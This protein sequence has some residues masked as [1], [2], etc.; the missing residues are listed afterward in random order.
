MRIRIP[1]SFLVFLIEVVG[2]DVQTPVA[3]PTIFLAKFPPV[4]ELLG[5][6]SGKGLIAVSFVKPGDAVNSYLPHCAGASDLAQT[7]LPASSGGVSAS[8]G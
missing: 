6:D 2:R 4:F 3:L 7:S 1:G 5:S 8:A